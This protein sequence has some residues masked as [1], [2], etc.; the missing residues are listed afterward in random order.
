MQMSCLLVAEGWSSR[1]PPSL[2]RPNFGWTWAAGKSIEWEKSKSDDWR[3]T[4]DDLTNTVASWIGHLIYCHDYCYDYVHYYCYEHRYDAVASH[5]NVCVCVC[6]C[7]CSF[8]IFGRRY[9]QY[10]QSLKSLFTVTCSP[11]ALEVILIQIESAD[12]NNL[13]FLKIVLFF[14]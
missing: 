1:P 4:S 3:N 13:F 5:F 11:P 6:V 2:V 9:V 10:F 14:F 7:C 8:H 12:L